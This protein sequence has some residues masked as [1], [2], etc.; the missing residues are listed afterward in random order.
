[1]LTQGAARRLSARFR[2]REHYVAESA[3]REKANHKA[4]R[5]RGL[6]T[7]C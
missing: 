2:C 5:L 3:L 7:F 4:V 6:T 1:M